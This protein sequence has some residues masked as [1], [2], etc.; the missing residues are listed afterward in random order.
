M[1]KFFYLYA[2]VTIVVHAADWSLDQD[3]L[4]WNKQAKETIEEIL[5][6]KP[7]R[8]IAKN[9]ILFIGDG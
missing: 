5:K 7:N 8:K 1:R 2:V 4:K 6:M 3:P 9:I